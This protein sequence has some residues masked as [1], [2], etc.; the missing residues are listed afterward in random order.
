MIYFNR[1]KRYK[2]PY[3]KP[4]KDTCEI[5]SRKLLNETRFKLSIYIKIGEEFVKL[6][7][8]II[9]EECLKAFIPYKYN[10]KLK[11]F[12]RF[13]YRELPKLETNKIQIKREAP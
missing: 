1:F 9:C 12:I 3:M 6:K 7:H 8:L 13:K 2:P 5:C 10:K 11:R 4:P